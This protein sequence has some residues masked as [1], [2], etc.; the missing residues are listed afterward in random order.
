MPDLRR[1]RNRV[2]ALAAQDKDAETIAKELKLRVQD[3]RLMLIA[4]P[5]KPR[6][7]VTSDA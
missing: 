5:P 6:P 3:V 2:H 7:K 1:Y 4:W